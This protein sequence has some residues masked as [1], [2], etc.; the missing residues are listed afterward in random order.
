MHQDNIESK[1]DVNRATTTPK[2]IAKTN[3]ECRVWVVPIGI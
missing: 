3:L 1:K 2:F